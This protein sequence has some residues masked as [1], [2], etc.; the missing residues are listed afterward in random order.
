MTNYVVNQ[1][2]TPILLE[3]SLFFFFEIL[4][5]WPSCLLDIL[6]MASQVINTVHINP[7]YMKKG[8]AAVGSLC[9]L[10]KSHL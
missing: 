1:A 4:R 9:T 10:V 8:N 6:S 3:I 7:K 5:I 2:I